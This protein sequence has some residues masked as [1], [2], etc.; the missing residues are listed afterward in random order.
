MEKKQKTIAVA[1]AG[2]AAAAALGI[3][4][5]NLANAA[6]TTVVGV[7]GYD[8]AATGNNGEGTGTPAGG[9]KQMR[10][11]GGTLTEDAASKSVAAAS[12]EVSDGTVSSVRATSDGGYVV[13]VTKTDDTHVHVL[14]DSDFAVTSVE[15][16]GMRGSGGPSGRE[17]P[18]GTD[19][20]TPSDANGSSATATPAT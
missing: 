19:S 7:P 6:D 8:Q 2:I 14:L 5:A 4:G 20:S 12:A 18:G 16:G 3:A 9:G 17:R 15:E 1:G 11:G 13:D 10:D